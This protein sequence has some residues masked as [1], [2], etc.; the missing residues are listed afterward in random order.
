MAITNPN[1]TTPPIDNDMSELKNRAKSILNSID[2][3]LLGLNIVP[4]EEVSSADMFGQGFTLGWQPFSGE[5]QLDPETGL[6]LQPD[7]SKSL[8]DPETGEPLSNVAQPVANLAQLQSQISEMSEKLT[9]LQG[10]IA[11][12]QSQASDTATKAILAENKASQAMST[13]VSALSKAASALSKAGSCS[14]K[15]ANPAEADSD[16]GTPSYVRNGGGPQ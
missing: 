7:S 10:N 12:V 5:T 9:T 8:I 3:F 11:S 6:P 1:D 16:A 14:C 15:P 13:A 2:N 4:L